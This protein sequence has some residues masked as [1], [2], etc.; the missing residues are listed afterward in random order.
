MSKLKITESSGNIFEDL[1][2]DKEEAANLLIRTELIVQIRDYIQKRGLKQKTAA[3]MLS[4]KQPD[5]SAIMQLKIEKFTIDRLVNFLTRLN[6]KVEISSKPRR[7]IF[8]VIDGSK[9]T[10]A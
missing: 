7:R 6:H 3:D 2:F 1:G 10:H 9:V 5:I 8:Q 4:V